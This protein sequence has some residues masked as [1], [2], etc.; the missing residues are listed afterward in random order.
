MGWRCVPSLTEVHVPCLSLSTLVEVAAGQ[1]S[2]VCSVSGSAS[3]ILAA[4]YV[5]ERGQSPGC[6]ACAALARKVLTALA[7]PPRCLTAYAPGGSFGAH[8]AASSF[9]FAHTH[10]REIPVVSAASCLTGCPNKQAR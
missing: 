5:K 3:C 2:S 9:N 10:K 8:P 7:A 6:A 1:R 4:T